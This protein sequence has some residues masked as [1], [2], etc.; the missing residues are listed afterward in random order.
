MTAALTRCPVCGGT[1]LCKFDEIRDID[2]NVC[3]ILMC[4]GCSA[5]LNRHAY[6]SLRDSTQE[7]VQQTDMY[8][9][10]P[11]DSPDHHLQEIQRAAAYFEYLAGCGIDTT[12][13]ADQVFCDFGAGRGYV[14]LAACQRFRS[15]VACDWDTRGIAGVVQSLKELGSYYE[16][17][18]VIGD[19]GDLHT[20]IDV[21]FM[22]H[23]LEHLQEPTQFWRSRIHSLN[24]DA[25]VFLQIPL[26]RPTSVCRPHY[27]F[28]T[29]RSLEFW[30][31]A[32]GVQ[33]LQFGYDTE[34]GFL[35]MVGKYRSDRETRYQVPAMNN[36]EIAVAQRY[37][38]SADL[39]QLTIEPGQ[40]G[41]GDFTFHVDRV[42]NELTV[43]S[44][45][46]NEWLI[47]Q[48]R[49]L[50]SSAFA[51]EAVAYIKTR[52]LRTPEEV[53]VKART[54]ELYDEDYYLRRGGGGPYVGYPLTVY[55]DYLLQ[56]FCE[57][58]AEIAARFPNARVLDI[59]CG[60]GVF[61]RELQSIG[62]DA[63][64]MDISKWCIANAVAADIHHG[65]GL[66]M[67]FADD[68]FDLQISQDVME[69]IHPDD[70][71]QALREQI[72]VSRP[73][74]QLCH[75]IPFYNYAEPVSMEAHL[76][77]ANKDWWLDL[78]GAQPE[79]TLE[80]MASDDQSD[81]SKGRLSRYFI[82]RVNKAS[83]TRA[84]K[85]S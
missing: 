56:E 55:G 74:G 36:L 45:P 24:D 27:I 67:P 43:V 33:P 29:E 8:A 57:L 47:S 54:G 69:H 40:I 20:K 28:Y 6:D 58:A 78:F 48:Q 15:V 59:G 3:I 22:W 31:T 84:R 46:A 14:A 25:L 2:G 75:F 4:L 80:Q 9:V 34:N 76:C 65:S 52:I 23:V 26:Y 7:Q 77:S 1:E 16:N 35:G 49:T 42:S 85:L 32:I 11:D 70:L 73:G 19:F 71:G 61:V 68:S 72:R 81:V 79:L 41:I 5:L 82:F 60:P 63:H 39:G 83:P 18:E 44:F 17:L 64:G 21:L 12:R 62:I 37:F 10:T 50:T 66:A 13:F 38:N 51:W 30:A 53:V